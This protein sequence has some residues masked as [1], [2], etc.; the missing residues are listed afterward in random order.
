LADGIFLGLAVG[1]MPEFT[2]E[3]GLGA[4]EMMAQNAEGSGSIAKA[5][6]DVSRGKAFDEVGPEGLI[7]ALGW[8]SGFEEETGF[9]VDS[10]G[11]LKAIYCSRP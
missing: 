9:G 2:E 1:A 5:A 3:V 10:S 4:A 7:L 8:G 11:V 6:G